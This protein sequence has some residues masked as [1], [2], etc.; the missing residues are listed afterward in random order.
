MGA[1]DEIGQ[2]AF[3]RF[4][5]FSKLHSVAPFWIPDPAVEKEGGE[6]A[7]RALLKKEGELAR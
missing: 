7:S 3:P 5:I 6:E 4:S 2:L 1:E